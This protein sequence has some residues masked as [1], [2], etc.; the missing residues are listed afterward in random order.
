MLPNQM[1]NK[2]IQKSFKFGIVWHQ[3]LFQTLSRDPTWNLKG[4]SS[5]LLYQQPVEDNNSISIG[6]VQLFLFFWTPDGAYIIEILNFLIGHPQLNQNQPHFGQASWTFSVVQKSRQ[7]VCDQCHPSPTI[8]D[9][10]YPPQIP[11]NVSKKRTKS[12][13]IWSL[14]TLPTRMVPLKSNM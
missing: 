3:V 12:L 14:C 6:K 10:W 4:N 9:P 7:P 13:E 2:I 11:I 5:P 1:K 8:G